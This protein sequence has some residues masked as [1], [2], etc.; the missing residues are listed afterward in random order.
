[1]NLDLT[2]ILDAAARAAYDAR[3]KTP[4]SPAWE[5]LSAYQ[6][7][8]IKSTLLVTVQ[9]AAEETKAQI[10][11]HLEVEVALIDDPLAFLSEQ[12]STLANGI[13]RIVRDL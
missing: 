10:K 13:D 4:N 6:K 7:Q 3:V 12:A 2:P 8:Q 1:M 5:D 9:A 11:R